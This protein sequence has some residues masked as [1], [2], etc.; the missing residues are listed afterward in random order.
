MKKK[1]AVKMPIL[2][3]LVVAFEQ[4]QINGEFPSYHI[5]PF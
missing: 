4:V 5:N 2:L 3:I 1:Y